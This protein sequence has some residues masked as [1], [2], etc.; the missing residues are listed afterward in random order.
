MGPRR[1]KARECDALASGPQGGATAT[2][3]GD[4][5]RSGLV[6]PSQQAMTVYRPARRANGD[7]SSANMAGTPRRWSKWPAASRPD[8]D[9]MPMTPMVEAA[10]CSGSSSPRPRSK[11][12]RVPRGATYPGRQSRTKPAINTRKAPLPRQ[13]NDP[14][15]SCSVR[16]TSSRQFCLIPNRLRRLQC[17]VLVDEHQPLKAHCHQH[18]LERVERTVRDWTDRPITTD[19]AGLAA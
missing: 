12:P 5:R 18:L 16:V 10:G 2:N 3:C 19:P 17:N 14:R 8:S 6:R 4:P 11:R 9:L 15:S 13:E 1:R 7:R